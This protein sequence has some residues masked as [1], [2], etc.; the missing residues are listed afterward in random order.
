MSM[1][2]LTGIHG[3]DKVLKKLPDELQYFYKFGGNIESLNYEKKFDYENSFDEISVIGMILADNSGKY[4]IKIELFNVT[5]KIAFDMLNGFFL[6]FTIEDNF[7][8]GYESIKR[9]RIASAE[10]DI[11]FE[12]FC[13]D[14][15][16]E[17]L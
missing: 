3:M 10:Q 11:S 6:G 5:G 2:K 17:L 7:D 9:Y 1:K 16:I 15:S 4:R 12:V 8:L 14:I 13:E